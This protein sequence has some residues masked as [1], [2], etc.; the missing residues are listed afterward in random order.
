MTEEAKAAMKRLFDEGYEVEQMAYRLFPEG[1]DAYTGFAQN[2]FENAVKNTKKLVAAKTL[3]IFQPTISNWDLFCRA[4]ILK[5]NAKTGKYDIFEVKSATV[6]K[7]V[8]L[9]DLAF[10]KICFEKERIKI[11][12]LFLVH[13]NNKYTRN[14][15]IVPDGLLIR[16][17]VTAEVEDLIRRV[18]LDIKAAQRVLED[19]N[20]EPEVMILKQCHKPYDCEFTHYCW[21][22]IPEDSIYEIAGG[23]S[24]NKLEMLLDM[25]ILKIKDIPDGYVTSGNGLRHLHAVKTQQVFIDALAIKRELEHLE[26]PLYFLDYETFNPA[27][28]LFDGY[29]PYQR[30]VFQ[31]SLHV[32]ETPE[33]ELKH[34]QYLSTSI[35]DPTD[36]LEKSL[37]GAMGKQGNVIAWNKSFEAGCNS[38]MCDRCR[39]YAEF[40]ES[41]NGR[42]YD[43]MQP[44]KKGYYVHKDFKGSASIKKVLP[45][46]VPELSYKALNIQEGGT[47]S[48]S[49]LKVA[50]PQIAPAE[51]NQL[52]Q[53]MLAYCKLDTLAMVRILEVLDGL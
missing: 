14:G 15:E 50:N 5:L 31:Y 22:D 26:Y 37:A 28:P 20:E 17:N 47:A 49:W 7:D 51:R 25:G 41:I 2:D 43:L 24:H 36:E 13:I 35:A 16:E 48:E 34:Y 38:E 1:I 30:V 19:K 8:H 9:I 23:L 6:V 29:K 32:K 27:I 10:Q 12:E 39:D 40:F 11:G 44:F 42:M 45:V 3:V 52:A 46:L 33:A 4:D 21:R 53:D 18:G